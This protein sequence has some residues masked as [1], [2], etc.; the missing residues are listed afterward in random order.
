LSWIKKVLGGAEEPDRSPGSGPNISIDTSADAPD[1]LVAHHQAAMDTYWRS[2]GEVEADVLSYLVNPMFQ[3]GPPWPNTRQAYR[4]VRTTDSLIVASDGLSDPFPTAIS[5]SDRFG[6]GMEAFI[7]VKGLQHLTVDEIRGHWLFAAIENM[8]MNV[9]SAGGFVPM[10]DQ[11]GIL[12]IELPTDA[13]PDG[14]VKPDGMLGALIDLPTGRA[15]TVADTPIRPV[16]IV[17]ITILYPVEI[18]DCASGAS[19]RQ[20]MA[21][22]L[23][24]QASAHVTDPTRPPLR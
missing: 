9:A 15:N 11:H 18:D 2:I 5:Q 3:G 1:E 22:D 7:E 14:W 6:F 12:S 17:P 24:A 16:R 20:A 23:A 8:A 13:G 4:I 21:A 10:L 19:A